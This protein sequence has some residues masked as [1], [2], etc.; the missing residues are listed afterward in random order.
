MGRMF[1]GTLP[2]REARKWWH[3]WTVRGHTAVLEPT[4]RPGFVDTYLTLNTRNNVMWT[5][6]S[7]AEFIKD[8]PISTDGAVY[9]HHVTLSEHSDGDEWIEA[10]VDYWPQNSSVVEGALR[11]A[12]DA[13]RNSGTRV[14]LSPK[15]ICVQFHTHFCDP[16]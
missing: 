13:S 12:L 15:S 1:S 4:N 5:P 2:K 11:F 8:H 3:W 10:E 16:D 6:E 14:Y 9:P 7:I